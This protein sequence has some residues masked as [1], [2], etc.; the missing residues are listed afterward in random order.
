MARTDFDF[1]SRLVPLILAFARARGLDV[2]ALATRFSLPPEALTGQP[3]KLVMTTSVSV[4]VDLMELLSTQLNDP[5]VGLAFAQAVPK[6]AYGVAEFLVRAAPTLQPAF[7]NFTRFN[8]LIAP[9]QTFKF[10]VQDDAQ[11]HHFCTQRPGALGR[12]LN[13]YTTAITK[14]TLVAMAPSAKLLRAWFVTP[15]PASLDALHAA[16]GDDV[17]FSFEQPT[18][19]FS[20]P[21]ELLGRTV[22]GGDPALGAFLEEHATQALAS[23]PRQDDLIDK[24]RHFIRDAV[25]AG[26]PNVERLATRLNMSARTLQRR[27][28]DLKTSFQEVLDDVRFDLARAYLRDVRLDVSQVAYLLGYSELRAFDRAFKRWAGRSP[29]EWRASS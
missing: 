20:V 19:G 21:L 16:F 11:L 1:E 12:H 13:E 24:L 9:S 18:S 27:L 23:R 17:T 25:K 7:E 29:G 28:S 2:A 26:E 4:P 5:H 8:G 3:G 10:D 15:R 22:E 14:R 6:G